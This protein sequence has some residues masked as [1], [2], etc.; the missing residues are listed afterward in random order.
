MPAPKPYTK[1]QILDAMDKT[2]SVRA[3]ARYLNCS[4]WHL[5]DWMKKY[6]DDATGKTLFELHKNP[7]GK[8][9]PKFAAN[10]GNFKRKDPP[11]LDII[12]GRIDASNFSPKKLK[13]R[14]VIEGRWK[15]ECHSCGFHER[16]V[17]D[18]KIPLIL[19]F[20]DGKSTNW[21]NGN[22]SLVCYNCYFLYYGQ[23]FNEKEI[24]KL[25]SHQTTQKIQGDQMQLDDYNVK[26]LR[27]LGFYDDED[28]DPY[29]LVSKNI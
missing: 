18:N 10:G 23:I 8:G 25:E 21:G 11:L 27:E 6:T 24:D 9:I 19:H 16:R 12:E 13:H 4:Y 14:M 17:L 20:K 29:S 5:K 22:A 26:R 15:E 1:G 7:S 28:D 2:K 3:A